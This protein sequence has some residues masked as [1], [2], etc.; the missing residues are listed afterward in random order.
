M[1]IN[2]LDTYTNINI[3][4]DFSYTPDKVVDKYLD[5]HAGEDMRHTEFDVNDINDDFFP[6]FTGEIT[7]TNPELPV[8]NIAGVSY[9]DGVD[10]IVKTD[11]FEYSSIDKANS[12]IKDLDQ[13][14]VIKLNKFKNFVLS[15]PLIKDFEKRTNDWLEDV[16]DMG[17]EAREN[18]L[19]ESL[20]K[21]VKYY[22]KRK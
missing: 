20:S 6:T 4:M 18:F 14:D 8:L 21:I 7:S 17:E 3:D 10:F 5:D 11:N 13:K 19:E 1:I 2:N 15:S 22:L 12:F 16:I 9:G